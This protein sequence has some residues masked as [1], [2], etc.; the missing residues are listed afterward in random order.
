MKKHLSMACVTALLPIA[1]VA[2]RFCNAE[3]GPQ[4]TVPADLLSWETMDRQAGL[5]TPAHSDPNE[6]K[7]SAKEFEKVADFRALEAGEMPAYWRLMRWSRVQDFGELKKEA[8]QG[9]AAASYKDLIEHPEKHRG[10]LIQLDLHVVRVLS[11]AAPK[12]SAGVKT[13]YEAWG[14]TQDSGMNPYVV[15]FAE[16]PPELPLGARVKDEATFVGYFLKDMRYESRGNVARSAP[17]LIGRLRRREASNHAGA[18]GAKQPA[19]AP[20]AK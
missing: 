19:L 3:T 13:V 6:R 4:V 14:I 8:R 9:S 16:K 17:L 1:I 10:A 15:V 7:A 12:N 11:F 20:A 18:N 5:Q 2:P